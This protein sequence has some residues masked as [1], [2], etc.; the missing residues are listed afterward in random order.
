M[1]EKSY[2]VVAIGLAVVLTAAACG[3][4]GSDASS[5]RELRRFALEQDLRID[6]YEAD[7]VPISWVGVSPRGTI[8]LFQ[9]QDNT[10]RFFDDTGAFLGAVGRQGEGPGE[11]RRMVRAGWIADT[12]WVSDTQL[13]RVTL[14]SPDL[15]VI[16]VVRN[17]DVARPMPADDRF[18]AY[19]QPSPYALYSDGGSMVWALRPVDPAQARGDDEPTLVLRLAEDGSIQGR[20]A[21]I[22]AY[23]GLSVTVEL[24]GGFALGQIPFVPGPAW[25]VSPD[26]SRLGIL[27]TD[28]AAAEPSYRVY[29][30]DDGG[31]VVI[32]RSFTFVPEPIPAE[33]IDSVIEARVS[34]MDAGAGEMESKMRAAAPSVF[35]EAERLVIGADDRVWVGMRRRADGTRWLVLSSTGDPVGDIVLPPRV[36][37]SAADGE[38]VWCIERD[39]FDVGSVVRYRILPSQ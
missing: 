10:V 38:H 18:T 8:A 36:L 22:P 16:R 3:M 29:V 17:H 14:I 20:V 1:N 9:G 32:D 35:G 7:L 19:V 13:R 25:T 6:G 30:V 4:G 21:S 24:G 37:L 33:R 2:R 5:T 11:F 23:A 12:L 28:M 27:T 39:E 31:D 26:G 34:R 15:D